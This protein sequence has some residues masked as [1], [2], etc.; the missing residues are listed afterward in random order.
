MKEVLQ[1]KDIWNIGISQWI[2]FPLSSV[3]YDLHDSL[4]LSADK[5]AELTTLQITW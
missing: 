5:N 1:M 3:P 4:L 2:G